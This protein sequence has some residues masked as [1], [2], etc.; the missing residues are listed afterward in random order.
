MTSRTSSSFWKKFHQLPLPIQQLARKKYD[1]WL[2]NFRHRSVRFKP[3]AGRLYSARVGAHYRALGY[4]SDADEFTWTW[5]G[6]HAEY[7]QIIR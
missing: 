1:L 3:V 2:T 7:D 6:T 4:F 5:I